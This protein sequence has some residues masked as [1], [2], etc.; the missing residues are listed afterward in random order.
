MMVA[1]VS[2]LPF[3]PVSAGLDRLNA[4]SF[5]C[6]CVSVVSTIRPVCPSQDPSAYEPRRHGVTESTRELVASIANRYPSMGFK[7][8]PAVFSVS[9]CLR[10]EYDSSGLPNHASLVYRKKFSG[11]ERWLTVET[12]INRRP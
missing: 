10:G 12:P 1:A 8:I 5:P 3:G 7:F 2:R 6:L 9:L 11:D 4:R